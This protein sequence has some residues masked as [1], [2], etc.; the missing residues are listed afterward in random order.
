MPAP[1][2][3]EEEVTVTEDIGGGMTFTTYDR[4]PLYDLGSSQPVS[5][6]QAH[7]ATFLSGLSQV[8]HHSGSG[9][10][11]TTFHNGS[12]T[13]V[14]G[15][16]GGGTSEMNGLVSWAENLSENLAANGMMSSPYAG[17][18]EEGGASQRG[19]VYQVGAVAGTAKGRRV[20]SERRRQKR[21][22]QMMKAREF[23]ALKQAEEIRK[24]TEVRVQEI[25][26][27]TEW[28]Q[29]PPAVT[30]RPPAAW[31]VTAAGPPADTGWRAPGQRI[32]WNW[33]QCME[34]SLFGEFTVPN[35]DY[36]EDI[37]CPKTMEKIS[38]SLSHQLRKWQK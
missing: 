7:N 27:H 9:A 21:F 20:M 13:T 36:L 10:S 19:S 33:V 17:R 6:A 2:E 24:R 29:Q 25:P 22:D 34:Y 8:P 26:E 31:E 5:F 3:G 28:P 18:Q 32:D 37:R 11:S 4:T 16:G 30:P 14:H 38:L 23:Q 35:L 1:E 12:S 15:G